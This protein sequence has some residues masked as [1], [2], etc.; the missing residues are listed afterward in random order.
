MPCKVLINTKQN[1]LIPPGHP[2]TL[3]KSNLFN[4][5]A[6]LVKRSI[7]RAF[8][9][10]RGKKKERKKKQKNEKYDS[11]HLS[12]SFLQVLKMPHNSSPLTSYPAN[13]GRVISDP[14]NS[15]IYTRGK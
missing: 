5:A 9:I 15:N 14:L 12:E 3:L 13:N 11:P 6:A 1:V 10:L 7:V 2:I 4:M 8:W